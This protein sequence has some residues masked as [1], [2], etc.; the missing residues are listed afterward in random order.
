[1]ALVSDQGF[2]HILRVLN[3]NVDGRQKARSDACRGRSDACGKTLIAGLCRRRA[4][5]VLLSACWAAPRAA[6]AG[7]D[8]SA[9]CALR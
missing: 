6:R 1:M 9:C 8:A 5:R 3:T 2:Q 7:A 4:A